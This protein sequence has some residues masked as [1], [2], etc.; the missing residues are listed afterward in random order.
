MNRARFYDLICAII[1]LA[2]AGCLYSL[3]LHLST[4]H[5]HR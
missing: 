2:C 1:I 3:Y 4:L 5:Y